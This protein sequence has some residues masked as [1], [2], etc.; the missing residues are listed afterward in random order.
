MVFDLLWEKSREQ[1]DEQGIDPRKNNNL[2]ASYSPL[3]GCVHA[4]WRYHR[5]H[6]GAEHRVPLSG[7]TRIRRYPGLKPS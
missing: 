3:L 6:A 2:F 1:G 5:F 4:F 7:R